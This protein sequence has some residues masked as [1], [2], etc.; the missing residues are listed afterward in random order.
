MVR[1]AVVERIIVAVID[2][3]LAE[4]ASTSTASAL[5]IH[6]QAMTVRPISS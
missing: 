6:S 2:G 4:P 1:G 5:R 3:A